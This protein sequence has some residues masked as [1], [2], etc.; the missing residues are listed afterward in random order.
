MTV[1]QFLG[2]NILQH[3]T[4]LY[5]DN[6]LQKKF[7]VTILWSKFPPTQDASL[8]SQS[9]KKVSVLQFFGVN[10]LQHKTTSLESRSDKNKQ[11]M[12]VL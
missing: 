11:R 1:L 5:K 6:A 9:L 12:I 3:K 2:V 7:C 4:H 10:F 8:Q